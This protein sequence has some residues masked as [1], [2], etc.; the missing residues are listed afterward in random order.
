MA[1]NAAMAAAHGALRS[2]SREVPYA[3]L[4]KF[5]R[6]ITEPQPDIV[7]P[8]T[9]LFFPLVETNRN[10]PENSLQYLFDTAARQLAV[11]G[12]ETPDVASLMIQGRSRARVLRFDPHVATHSRFYLALATNMKDLDA[13]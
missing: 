10:H 12:S 1:G 7:I 8:E 6:L 13:W 11:R 9:I 3:A 2:C 5:P 4:A